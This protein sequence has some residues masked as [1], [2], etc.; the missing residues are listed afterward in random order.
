VCVLV[1]ILI[2]DYLKL[3]KKI[4]CLEKQ[5]NNIDIVEAAVLEALLTARAKKNYL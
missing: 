2:L 5:K 1:D 4:A 3:D